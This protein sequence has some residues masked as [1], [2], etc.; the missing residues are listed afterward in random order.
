MRKILPQLSKRKDEKLYYRIKSYV[1][2]HATRKPAF[3]H[4][5]LTAWK[6]CTK[7]PTYCSSYL[8]LLRSII[9]PWIFEWRQLNT[10]SSSSTYLLPVQCDCNELNVL[11]EWAN[12]KSVFIARYERMQTH[13]IYPRAQVSLATN[14]KY[15]LIHFEWEKKTKTWNHWANSGRHQRI[16]QSKMFGCRQLALYW[17]ISQFWAFVF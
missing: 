4:S 1:H 13:F 6:Y 5:Q 2:P 15:I 7:N 16:C 8:F 11:L 9:I 12:W 14:H 10:C 17:F 3:T